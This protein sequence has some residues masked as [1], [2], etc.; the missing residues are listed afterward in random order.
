MFTRQTDKHKI[1]HQN[2]NGLADKEYYELNGEQ[3]AS[4]LDLNQSKKE[5]PEDFFFH[6]YFTETVCW[7][8]EALL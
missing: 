6:L 2:K 5:A 8:V 1:C 4:T 7:W 3:I